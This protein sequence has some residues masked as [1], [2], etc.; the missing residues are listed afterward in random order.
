[1]NK[2]ANPLLALLAV[3]L[4]GCQSLYTGT[5]TL[6]KVVDS[7][8]KEYAKLYNDGLV[9]PDVS[10]KVSSAFANY[11]KSAGV[12]HDA[13]VAYKLGQTSDTRTAIEAAR[14][15]ASADGPSSGPA[16]SRP[17]EPSPAPLP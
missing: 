2:S 15:A 13:L 16:G 14:V 12:A 8:A 10:A 7:A 4:I 5:V 9:P 11:Q 17:C 1:M 6:T 3:V